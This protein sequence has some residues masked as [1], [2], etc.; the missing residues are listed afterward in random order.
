MK[1]LIFA[2]ALAGV[3]TSCSTTYPLAATNNPI[4]SKVGTSTTGSLGPG[5]NGM[6]AGLV[7]NGKF[8]V[9]DAVKNGKIS[10]IASVDIKVTNYVFF[11]KYTL[12]VTGE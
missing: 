11:S 8:G 10:S 2:F 7:F 9:Q 1:K 3:I 12:I 6:P 4:G 5:F